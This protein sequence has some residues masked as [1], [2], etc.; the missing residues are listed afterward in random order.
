MIDGVTCKDPSSGGS[1]IEATIFFHQS[2][3]NRKQQTT[4]DQKKAAVERAI[5]LEER[6]SK[7]RRKDPALCGSGLTAYAKDLNVPFEPA[8]SLGRDTSDMKFSTNRLYADDPVWQQKRQEQ[9]PNL[10]NFL[11]LL[12]GVKDGQ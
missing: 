9:L 11:L 12:V 7:V 3:L 6:S 8:G 2:L 1:L 4:T 5:K 10:R